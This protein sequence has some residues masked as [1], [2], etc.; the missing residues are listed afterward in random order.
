MPAETAFESPA[1]IELPAVPSELFATYL[2]NA[3]ENKELSE[4]RRQTY[5]AWQQ[6]IAATVVVDGE[7]VNPFGIDLAAIDKRKDFPAKGTANAMIQAC[8]AYV[9]AKLARY[10]A[11]GNLKKDHDDA[12]FI[13]K[14]CLAAIVD[15]LADAKK[16][17]N[18]AI[19]AGVSGNII[20]GRTQVVIQSLADGSLAERIAN[21]VGF[22]CLALQG[23]ATDE[24]RFAA[25]KVGTDLVSAWLGIATTSAAATDATAA[26]MGGSID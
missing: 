1:A 6:A 11:T 16:A 8:K 12:D 14:A 10:V 23:S 4:S 3:V 9:A 24:C 20:N 5:A 22:T 19:K 18:K 17:A 2:A 26:A 25:N 7:R 15:A 21:V 13:V